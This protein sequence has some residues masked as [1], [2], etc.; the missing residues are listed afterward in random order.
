MSTAG[1]I[2]SQSYRLYVIYMRTKHVPKRCSYCRI[3]HCSTCVYLMALL[4]TNAGA[5]ASCI[6]RQKALRMD[7]NGKM[8]PTFL[9]SRDQ[10]YKVGKMTILALVQHVLIANSSNTA[11]RSLSLGFKLMLYFRYPS[12]VSF[13][14]AGP[15]DQV[16][17]N[18]K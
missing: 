12:R 8:V 6:V 15:H 4:S 7:S 5:C 16:S 2:A 3:L 17:I 1:R 18:K 9:N 11:V 10:S 14:H 13:A